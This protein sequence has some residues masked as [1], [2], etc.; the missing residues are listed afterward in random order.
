MVHSWFQHLLTYYVL[1]QI[2]PL[3]LTVAAV[4]TCNQQEIDW[5]VISV[6]RK[7]DLATQVPEM[8]DGS[9]VEKD[10]SIKEKCGGRRSKPARLEWGKMS[11]H[12][13]FFI[14]NG[15]NM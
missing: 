13:L 3:V 4:G 2:F 5:P 7:V 15:L 14:W 8:S 6:S 1:K 12:K 9:H 10:C 11:D